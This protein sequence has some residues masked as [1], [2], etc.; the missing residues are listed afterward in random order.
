MDTQTIAI[1][2][3][4]VVQIIV[5]IIAAWAAIASRRAERAANHGNEKIAELQEHLIRMD[6]R[7]PKQR[8]KARR[9]R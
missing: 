5:A 3:S 4:G 1:L 2:V 7:I 9:K 6:K 8:T